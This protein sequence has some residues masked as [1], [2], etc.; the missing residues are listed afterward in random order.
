MLNRTVWYEILYRDWPW[1]VR[2]SGSSVLLPPEVIIWQ[3]GRGVKPALSN[4]QAVKDVKVGSF[5]IRL[6]TL[7]FTSF[8][9]PQDL[10]MMCWSYQPSRRPDFSKLLDTL[11]KLPK[12][13]GLER[14]PSHPGHLL[15]S[16][17]SNF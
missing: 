9:G 17:E 14:S 10:L 8:L 7:L 2:E 15:R 13:K 5:V 4:L 6:R 12:R 16:A 1:V 11:T 3:V